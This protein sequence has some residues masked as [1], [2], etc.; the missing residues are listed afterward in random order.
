MKVDRNGMLYCDEGERYAT[1]A[2]LIV[3]E[4]VQETLRKIINE[5]LKK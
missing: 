2:E 5:S 3:E 4:A 1:L